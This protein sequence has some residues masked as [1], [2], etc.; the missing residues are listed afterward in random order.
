MC[1]KRRFD[2]QWEEELPSA[3]G[4]H[5]FITWRLITWQIVY[6]G[7][8]DKKW[9]PRAN[10]ITRL[11]ACF[12]INSG[13]LQIIFTSTLLYLSWDCRLIAFRWSSS[14][15]IFPCPKWYVSQHCVTFM[16][17]Y[18][19][20]AF[21]VFATFSPRWHLCIHLDHLFYLGSRCI[22][23]SKGKRSSG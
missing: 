7:F 1:K 16:T 19:L 10:E 13:Y 20:I 12:R 8:W 2:Q 22:M 14:L 4:C 6:V 3:F 5:K 21:S 17:F 18:T 15:C 11:A 23:S 9:S